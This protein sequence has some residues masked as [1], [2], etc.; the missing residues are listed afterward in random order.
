MKLRRPWSMIPDTP[1]AHTADR[2]ALERVASEEGRD[3]VRAVQRA[4]RQPGHRLRRDQLRLGAHGGHRAVK[5]LQ[6]TAA[7]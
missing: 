3:G 7:E 6:H 1:K 5:H 4:L 2:A